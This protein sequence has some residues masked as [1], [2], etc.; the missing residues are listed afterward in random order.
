MRAVTRDLVVIALLLGAA[1][2]AGAQSPPAAG[3]AAPRPLTEA[4][5]PALR[6][7]LAEHARLSDG[8]RKLLEARAA[9]LPAPPPAAPAPAPPAS[10]AAEIRARLDRIRVERQQA[11][12][13]R[14]GALT[15]FDFSR[16]AQYQQ[17]IA[18]LDQE[19]SRLEQE[20]AALPATPPPAAAPAPP[21]APA[22]ARPVDRL[23]C[24]DLPAARAEALRL[25]QKE[26]GAREGQAGVVPLVPP[27]GQTPAD[28]ARELAAQLPDSAGAQL[29]LLDADADG[30]LDG[31][32]DA[33]TPGVYRLYR[34]RPDGSL[35]VETFATAAAASPSPYGEIPRRVEEGVA[36]QLRRSLADLLA[37]RP[38]GPVRVTAETPDFAAAHAHWLAGNYAEAA[39]LDGPALRV[40]EYQNL[41]GE[42]VR[43]SEILAPAAGGLVHRQVVAAARP[44][45]PEQW[46]E[47]LTLVRPVSFWRTEVEVSTGRETRG[48]GGVRVGARAAG[49]SARFGIDR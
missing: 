27:R 18:G 9:A 3:P 1:A 25:R 34:Q 41:R 22:A 33:P 45:D 42:A 44:G 36:R 32:V 40:L 30:R 11:E 2:P 15:R 38:A 47:T 31:F 19:R 24:A 12:D 6:D 23:A 10:R 35:G 16:V 37:V 17:Q 21:P 28:V 43:L 4:E 13:G 26:L 8:V 29:G 39:R 20:L 14:L 48:P 49:P 7:Q 5:C 46:D